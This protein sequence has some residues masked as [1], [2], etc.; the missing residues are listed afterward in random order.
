MANN[1][2]K[3]GTA[4]D[5]LSI[6]EGPFAVGAAG[7]GDYGPTS[8]TGYYAGID[9]PEGG[10]VF[11]QPD[12]NGSFNI[13]VAHDDTQAMFFLQSYGA[14][15]TTLNEMLTWASASGSVV[16]LSADITT[17]EIIEFITG[18]TSGSSGTSGSNGSS[19]GSQFP[20]AWAVYH[21]GGLV[22]NLCNK[23]NGTGE[24]VLYSMGNS[25]NKGSQLFFNA[26]LT[27]PFSASNWGNQLY[28]EET[29][30]VYQIDTSQSAFTIDTFISCN[31]LGGDGL[32]E[33]LVDFSTNLDTLLSG[34]GTTMVARKN[35]IMDSSVSFN[36]RT[37]F[38][39]SLL[40]PFGL[41]EIIYFRYGKVYRQFKIGGSGYAV[42][43]G[44]ITPIF[45][46][47]DLVYIATSFNDACTTSNGQWKYVTFNK[48]TNNPFAI[49]YT[50]AFVTLEDGSN[51]SSYTSD[52]A[53]IR[54][55]APGSN[56][57]FA[58]KVVGIDIGYGGNFAPLDGTTQ[59]C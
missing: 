38:A 6:Q 16:G 26:D 17:S 58:S 49:S 30:R 33:Y 54:I 7:L 28:V 5:S 39:S 37:I 40:T 4:D 32:D 15:G 46:R 24:R 22:A 10:Y 45:P 35:D 19:G 25:L 57:A 23:Q 31:Q 27:D 48:N 36:D 13:N 50:N 52:N 29:G 8:R 53:W 44:N 18:S 43:D 20:R 56:S 55:V 9:V 51:W 12:G 41:D 42:P 3:V 47:R 34:G 2:F 1:V 21:A 11:Y 14:T 59:S